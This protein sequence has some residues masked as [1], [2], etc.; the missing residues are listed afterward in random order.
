MAYQVLARK[1]RPQ[2]FSDVAGQ[3]HVTRTLLNALAQGR[4]AHGYIFSGHRGIGKTTIARIL[5]MALN[6]RTAIGSPSR[7]SPEPCGVC[8]SCTEVRAGNAVDVIEIDAATNRGIDEIREL[9]DAARYRPARDR[10]KIYILDEAHQI[11]DAAFNAL[12]KTLEEPPDHVVFMMATTQPEDIPQTIRSRCQHFSFHAVKFDDIL[13]QLRTIATE[14]QIDAGDDALALLAEAGDGSMRDALSIMDQAIASAPL[15]SIGETGET[16]RP[17]LDAAQIR[18]LMGTVPNTVFERILE[19]IGE[20]QSAPV[21]EEV[22]RLLNAGNSASQLAR[23]MVRY[24]RNVLMARIAGERTEL[25][26]LSPDERARAGRSALLFSEEDL[27]RFLG[28]M[29]RTFDELNY[30]Q[31]PRFHLEL[32][33]LKLVHLQRLLPVEQLLS[34]LVSG[35][36]S[37]APGGTPPGGTGRTGRTDSHRSGAGSV[38]APALVS[39]ASPAVPPTSAAASAPAPVPA[40]RGPAPASAPVARRSSSAASPEEA[41]GSRPAYSPFEADGRRKGNEGSGQSHASEA[42]SPIQNNNGPAFDPGPDQADTKADGK[43]ETQALVQSLTQPDLADD[44]SGG[45][46]PASQQQRSA[47]SPDADAGAHVDTPG[48]GHP[49]TESGSPT[50]ASLDAVRDQVCA[51]LEQAR[52]N[53]AAALLGNGLWSEDGDRILVKVGAKKTMLGLAINAEVEKIC[54][55]TMRTIANGSPPRQL[56]FMPGDPATTGGV[57]RAPIVQSGPAGSVQARALDNPLVRQAQELFGAEVRSVV[58]LRNK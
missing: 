35:A 44:P 25:L 21:I 20:N 17:Q 33:L 34:Q 13:V 24:L 10:Y 53:T 15:A 40:P 45:E 41:A 37:R 56:T 2:R 27:T 8:D 6:C 31:E 11:T 52:H 43:A 51:A 54:R 58:D 18:E 50:A 36:P 5:A 39:A 3:D 42:A 28:V 46:G 48:R 30:R 12:L 23:Q 22:N 16:G 38:P 19:A 47:P 26:Q 1:Y 49:S 32:G 14:E 9:R 55:E 7:P 29:L 4:I 57:A